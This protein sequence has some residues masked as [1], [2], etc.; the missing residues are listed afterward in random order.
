MSRVKKV[1]TK[2]LILKKIWNLLFDDKVLTPIILEW[3]NVHMTKTRL[4]Y[5]YASRSDTCDLDLIESYLISSSDNPADS[6]SRSLFP[7]ALISHSLWFFGPQ[8]LSSYKKWPGPSF[9]RVGHTLF[10]LVR[11]SVKSYL[12]LKLL[13]PKFFLFRNY[14][15]F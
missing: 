6:A 2:K 1:A 12:I 8:W 13:D 3:S 14:I 11:Q 9:S 10:N 15:L 5:K 4:K 7:T